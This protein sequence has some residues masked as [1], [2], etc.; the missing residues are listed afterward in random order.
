M[1]VLDNDE[2]FAMDEFYFSFFSRTREAFEKLQ[3]GL[4]STSKASRDTPQHAISSESTK[5]R[6]RVK[7]TTTFIRSASPTPDHFEGPRRSHEYRKS[8]ELLQV[9]EIMDD[10]ELISSSSSTPK[11]RSLRKALRDLSLGSFSSGRRSPSPSR[12]SFDS[13][14]RPKSGTSSAGVGTP[15]REEA[16][17]TDTG[18]MLWSRG[19]NVA[20]WMRQRSA[21]VGSQVGTKINKGVGKV[22]Q[23]W[24][25]EDTR[26]DHARWISEETAKDMRDQNPEERFQS[27]FALPRT[28]KLQGAYYGYVFR[29]FPFYGKMYISRH[30]FCFRS[31]LPGIKTKVPFFTSR[32]SHQMVL[33]I[34]DIETARKEKAYHW[35]NFGLVTV[36]R[37]HE[38][39]FFEFSQESARD[40]C[41]QVLQD[42]IEAAET[43]SVHND[44]PANDILGVPPDQ[45]WF[46]TTK[47][48]DDGLQGDL[49]D[50]AERSEEDTPAV[51]FD[52]NAVSMISFKP[53][54][55]MRITCL[56]IGSRGDVQ[57]YIALC[58]VHR[59]KKML[60]EGPAKGRTF[61]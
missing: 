23:F 2:T 3:S 41:L 26:S 61:L 38:E 43:E 25:G 34:K 40:E 5:F 20:D 33:P 51:L 39:L 55:P 22:S 48:L 52:S 28:E 32:S 13:V 54:E 30:Y 15:V 29:T 31:L 44:L 4:N 37:G 24:S 12:T 57:P 53:P 1:T 10:A 47:A 11:R 49:S 16:T 27:H 21:E 9:P 19:V 7:D 46:E 8:T 50:L 60:I 14:E 42:N 56:T 6:D 17:W 58:K 18:K 36:I 35:S 45:I 59:S